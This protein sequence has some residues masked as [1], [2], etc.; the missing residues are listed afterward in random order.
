MKQRTYEGIKFLIDVLAVAL[1]VVLIGLWVKPAKASGDKII[2][3]TDV[4]QSVSVSNTSDAFAANENVQNVEGDKHDSFALGISNSLGDVDI[5]DCLSSKQ[6]NTPLFGRQTTELNYWCAALHYDAIGLNE[7]AARLRCQMPEIR[8]MFK[9]GKHY[10][11]AACIGANTVPRETSDEIAS[12]LAP[13]LDEQRTMISEA[14]AAL[15]AAN[16]RIANLEDEA[17]KARK[18]ATRPQAKPEPTIIQQ[19]FLDDAK[20]SKLAAIRGDR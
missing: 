14:K 17:E 7:M 4:S 6:W 8:K 10:A 16:E 3:D 15:S 9:D 2:Q 19:P 5:N 13:I 11:E 1:I 18:R 20:R 12:Q